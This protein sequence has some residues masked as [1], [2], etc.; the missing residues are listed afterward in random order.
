MPRTTRTP[1]P[2][3]TV[4]GEFAPL[5][6]ELT[7]FMLTT[8]RGMYIAEVVGQGCSET[9]SRGVVIQQADGTH[10]NMFDFIRAHTKAGA[11]RVNVPGH[12]R[13]GSVRDAV[14]AMTR[15]LVARRERRTLCR[16]AVCHLP[17]A[18]GEARCDFCAGHDLMPEMFAAHSTEV[19]A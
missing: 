3:E 13:F 7:R 11:V 18:A 10:V 15:H 19:A 2:L 5:N 12:G 6:I 4:Q 8:E 14:E 16:C 9:S 17:V 1:Q